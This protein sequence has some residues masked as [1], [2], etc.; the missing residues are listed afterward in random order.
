MHIH[1]NYRYIVLRKKDPLVRKKAIKMWLNGGNF[2]TIRDK[3]GES[4]GKLSKDLNELR[5]EFPELDELR[6]ITILINKNK[7]SIEQVLK[8][9]HLVS[10]LE[11]IKIDIET[12]SD[13]ISQISSY[14]KDASKI[15]LQSREF[16]ALAEQKGVSY[17]EILEDFK[18]KI[19]EVADLTENKKKLEGECEALRNLIKELDKLK[20]LQDKTSQ[21]NITFEILDAIIENQLILEKLGFIPNTAEVLA[22]EL[23]KNGLDPENASKMLSSLL[24]KYGSLVEAVDSLQRAKETLETIIAKDNETSSKLQQTNQGFIELNDKLKRTFDE[25][26]VKLQ[27]EHEIR[28]ENLHSKLEDEKKK[29]QKTID[30]LTGNIETL[31]KQMEEMQVEIQFAQAIVDMLNSRD[32]SEN[33]LST[34]TER[35]TRALEQKRKG[36]IFFSKAEVEGAKQQ[37]IRDLSDLVKMDIVSKKE[38]E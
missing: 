10:E 3:T 22:K 5:K 14:G 27:N 16:Y 18:E 4:V 8:G 6:R 32:I 36:Y 26:K 1:L 34:L 2:S 24:S 21:H 31:K 19:E 20:K 17:S 13:A 37:L 25:Q 23:N 28:V 35:L 15:L 11:K 30:E 9:A 38:H 12:A 33:Q 7:S 29:A